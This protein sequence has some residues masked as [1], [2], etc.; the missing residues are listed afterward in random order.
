MASEWP[1]TEPCQ[2]LSRFLTRWKS[3]ENKKI[4]K[5]R[6]RYSFST[7]LHSSIFIYIIITTPTNNH[8]QYTPIYLYVYQNSINYKEWYLL[9]IQTVATRKFHRPLIIVIHSS[10]LLSV[11]GRAFEVFEA[12][13][14][15]TKVGRIKERVAIVIGGIGWFKFHLAPAL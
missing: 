4:D 2:K 1:D 14:I 12:I 5:W 13:S 7:Q 3:S 15:I 6:W 9:L 11:T 8:Y 10:S